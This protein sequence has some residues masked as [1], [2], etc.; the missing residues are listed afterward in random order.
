MSTLS[1]EC[2]THSSLD[3]G[4]GAEASHNE[5]CRATAP[6]GEWRLNFGLAIEIEHQFIDVAPAPGFARLEGAHDGVFG[7]MKVLG[8]VLVFG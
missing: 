5:T 3:T 8:G 7:G 6:F 4:R 2:T 1:A